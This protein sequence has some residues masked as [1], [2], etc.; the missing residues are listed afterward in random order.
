MSYPHEPGFKDQDTSKAAGSLVAPGAP[1][2]LAVI[3]ALLAEGPASPEQ[4]KAKLAERGREVLLTSIRARVCQLKQQGRVTD[5]GERGIG[6][7][8]VA[9]VKI[10]RLTTPAERQRILNERGR[11]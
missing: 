3:V 7:S 4:L 11:Q 10:W 6:E 5:T 8:G 9:R 1:S 2:M